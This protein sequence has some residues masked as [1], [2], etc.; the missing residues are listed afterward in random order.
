MAGA[1]AGTRLR[2]AVPRTAALAAAPSFAMQGLL[3]DFRQTPHLLWTSMALSL[4]A[5]GWA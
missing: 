1:G 2:G 5:W 4:P 3:L